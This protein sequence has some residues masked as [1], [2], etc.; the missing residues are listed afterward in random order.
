[1]TNPYQC[2][3]D[4]NQSLPILTNLIRE[5]TT[6]TN[7]NQSKSILSDPNQYYPIIKDHN[8]CIFNMKEALFVFPVSSDRSYLG[9]IS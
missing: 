4:P 2:E 6:P 3:T 9:M 8:F 1:M 5:L 7:I